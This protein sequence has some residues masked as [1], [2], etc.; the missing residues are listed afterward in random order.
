MG[1]DKNCTGLAMSHKNITPIHH[2]CAI[3]R[4]FPSLTLGSHCLFCC[5]LL[6]DENMAE[7]NEQ[8]SKSNCSP[9]RVWLPVGMV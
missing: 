6:K 3:R 8:I 2:F 1:N 9:K 4:Y 5:A 7:E